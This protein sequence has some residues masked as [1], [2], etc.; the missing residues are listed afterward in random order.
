MNFSI[1]FF[2]TRPSDEAHA[3]LDRISIVVDNLDAAMVKAKLLFDTLDMPQKPDGLRI[4]DGAIRL[5]DR[6]VEANPKPKP[7]M[8]TIQKLAKSRPVGVRN[9]C[10]TM[11]KGHIK[12]GGVSAK[13]RCKPSLMRCQ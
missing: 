8:P 4:L 1:E 10:C 11:T 3:T 5:V 7:R 2:R 12:G 13:R 9:P 6:L